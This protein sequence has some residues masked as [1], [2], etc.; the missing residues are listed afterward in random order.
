MG[1]DAEGW[2]PV[3]R[4][5]GTKAPADVVNLGYVV[6]VIE[7]LRERE[8]A[9]AD[10][11]QLSQ[12]ALVVAARLDWDIRTDQA[13]AFGDGVIT[14]R[15][16]FQKFFSQDELRKWIEATLGVEADAAAPGVFYVFR[17]SEN[18]EAYR[19]RQV[20]RVPTSRISIAPTA[21]F[22][23]NRELLE[24]L[25]RF[26]SE[27]GRP[28]AAGELD[29]EDQIASRLGSMSRAIKLLSRVSDPTSWERAALARQRDLLVYLA[30]GGFRRRP[31]F[32]AL[33]GDLRS[34]IKAFFGSYAEATRLGTEVLFAA[35][36]MKAVSQECAEAPVGKLTADSLYIHVTALADLPVLLRV[37]EGCARTLLGDVPG[38]TLVKLRRDKPKVSYLCYPEFDG[39][40]HPAI[41]ETFIAD[42][43]ALRVH[44]VDYRTRENP[45]VLHRKEC[46]VGEG[47]ELRPKFQALTKAEER[48]GLLEEPAVI[49]TRD[50]WRRRL[51]NAGVEVR[52]HRLMKVRAAP[53]MRASNPSVSSEP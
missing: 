6:N 13:V 34:D 29:I 39:E 9:L 14:T 24:P 30:L 17:S 19:A 47:Y 53:S 11:W 37:Y 1:V 43:K 36:Q 15:G 49:G 38:A 50:G 26:L 10:A 42:L 40:A 20:R 16:T 41:Q 2:D 45:P 48:A 8:A 23:Q 4:P 31:V 22:E 27:R 7:D 46:F 3:H 25:L 33:P 28:P 44:H 32:G 5:H 18:R 35:G 21:A 12:R 51:A 52:G